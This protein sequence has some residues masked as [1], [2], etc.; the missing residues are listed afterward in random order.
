M[1]ITKFLIPTFVVLLVIGLFSCNGSSNADSD[2]S[3]EESELETNFLNEEDPGP[4]MYT[5]DIPEYME[6]MSDLNDAAGTQYGYVEEVDGVVME[7]YFIIITETHEEIEEY[8]L[9]Y[10][11]DAESYSEIA[12][13]GLEEGLD[14]YTVLK[15]S[16]VKSVNGMDCVKSE[17]LGLLPGVSVYYKMGVFEGEYGFYQVL[18]WT[19]EDQKGEF[20]EEMDKIIDSFKEK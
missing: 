12:V 17:M 2:S 10:D 16:K 11:F 4:N 7:H 19:I 14:E 1:K 15:T 9:G 13:A 20:E 18:T 3:F 6:E 5:I 8:E